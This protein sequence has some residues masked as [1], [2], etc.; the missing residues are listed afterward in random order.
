MNQMELAFIQRFILDRTGIVLTPEKR[1]LVE[2]R[3]DPVMRH[4]QIAS[5]SAVA[6]RLRQGDRELELAVIDAMTTNET[7]FF[8]DRLPFEMFQNIIMPQLIAARRQAGKIR[9]WCAACSSGQ[10]PYSLSMILDDM[11]AQLAGIVV[12]I[13]ATDISRKVLQQAQEGIFSQ[14]EV[15]RGLPIKLLLKHFTQVSPRWHIN[16]ALGERIRFK[17]QNLLLPFRALGTFDLIFCRNVLIYFDEAT[18]R[19]VL[20][21]LAEVMA[22]DS[23]LM[24]GG[25]ETVLG[26]SPQLAPHVSERSLYVRH[27]SPQAHAIKSIRSRLTA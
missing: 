11:R 2:T 15:Q 12:E 13:V 27:D 3:L 9:I 23:Y 10:E 16:K 26:L 19:D 17:A 1:Y 5:L 24:L 18:K 6:A 8:R 20:G 25:A 22:P 21:R 14:F 7:L 4:F